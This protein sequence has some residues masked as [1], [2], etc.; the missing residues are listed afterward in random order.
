MAG[1]MQHLQQNVGGASGVTEPKFKV[2]RANG[3]MVKVRIFWRASLSIENT[4]DGIRPRSSTD[5]ELA[6][7]ST[8]H[9]HARISSCRTLLGPQTRVEKPVRVGVLDLKTHLDIDTWPSSSP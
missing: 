4:L 3:N 2:L 9:G 1:R 5:A 8:E 6:G 7:Q